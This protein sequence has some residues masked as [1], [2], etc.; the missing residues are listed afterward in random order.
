M[1]GWLLENIS[2]KALFPYA[3]IFA[4]GSFLTMAFVNHGDN[5]VESKKGLEAFDF[6]D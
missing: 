6:D 3:A 1:A 4:F 2:Y 5:R